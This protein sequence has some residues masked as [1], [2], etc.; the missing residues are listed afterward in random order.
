MENVKRQSF[1]G[2]LRASE[3]MKREYK[4][5]KSGAVLKKML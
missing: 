4:C 2:C 5:L 1:E 3:V